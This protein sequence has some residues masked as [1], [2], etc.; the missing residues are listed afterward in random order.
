MAGDKINPGDVWGPNEYS[1]QRVSLSPGL[2]IPKEAGGLSVDR[3]Q[4]QS[5]MGTKTV[6]D[7]NATQANPLGQSH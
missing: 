7:K 5:V 4:F 3:A 1:A 2:G 6:L